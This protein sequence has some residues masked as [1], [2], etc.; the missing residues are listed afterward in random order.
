MSNFKPFQ[1]PLI[2]FLLFTSVFTHHHSSV[3][4]ASSSIVQNR[5]FNRPDP[6]RHL[7]LYT[8]GY[9]IRNKH[10][11]ASAAFTGIHGYAMAGIWII[12]GLGFGSYL[13]IKNF[14]GDFH[15]FFDNPCSYYIACFALIAFFTL[16]AI[17]FSSLILVANQSSVQKSKNLMDTIF[18]AA[19]NMQQ[20]TESVIQGLL[21]IQSFLKPYDNHTTDLL[22]QIIDQMRKETISIQDFV[23][24]AKQTSRR[25]IKT[26][27]IAN[28]VFVT[29]NLV[30]LVVGCVIAICSVVLVLHWHPGFIMFIV[31]CWILTTVSWILTGFD[32]FF[33]IFAGDTCRVFEDFEQN[34]SSKQNGIMLILSSCSNSSNSDKFMAQIGYT[35]HKYIA[36][37]NS[38][39]TLLAHKMIEPN[40]QVDKSFAIERICD[41]FSGAPYYNYT[42]G[43]CQQDAIQIHDLPSIIST[44]TCKKD[45]PTEVCKT[46]GKFFPESSYGKTMSYIQSIQILISTYSDLQNLAGCT[47]LKR[48]ISD[49]ALHQCKPF[50]ASV[51]LLWASILTLSIDMM[52][53]TLFWI[54]KAYQ[55]KGRHFYFCSVVPKQVNQQRV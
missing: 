8:G 2:S 21:K 36:E 4:F 7:N 16:I 37:S 9:D 55:E 47:P 49:I 42:P 15:P 32:F 46:E 43:N 33:H 5:T 52:I 54:V 12:F 20:T 3:V 17:I 6:L 30:M 44:L 35:V 50:K 24:E 27:Y 39:I 19:T 45:T 25:A 13:I 14:N 22:N 48:A 51:K 31:V 26:V 1:F 29:L 38:E 53:L 11:W 23:G 34:Q 10:Y 41:P 28:L 40:D 18:G